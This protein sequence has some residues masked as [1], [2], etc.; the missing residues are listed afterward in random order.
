[1]GGVFFVTLMTRRTIPPQIDTPGGKFRVTAWWRPLRCPPKL[2][3]FHTVESYT[4]SV[5]V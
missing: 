2:V 3:E 5:F 4:N 1:M